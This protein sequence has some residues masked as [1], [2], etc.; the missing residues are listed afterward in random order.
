M[1]AS[2]GGTTT[3]GSGFFSLEPDG[4]S[5]AGPIVS[6][7]NT[8]TMAVLTGS[9]SPT[10][11]SLNDGSTLN[12]M[13]TFSATIT[14]TTGL[15]DGDFAIIYATPTGVVPEP[16]TLGMVGTGL[17]GILGFGRRRFLG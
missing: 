1:T 14:D 16:A 2:G 11:L 4:L 5:F 3:F 12:A 10:T 7:T 8:Y 13:P 15:T 17:L 6:S 9:L